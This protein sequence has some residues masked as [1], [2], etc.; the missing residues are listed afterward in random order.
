MQSVNWRYLPVQH[1]IP[2]TCQVFGNLVRQA[3]FEG[4]L[5]DSIRTK[6]QCVALFPKNFSEE[7]TDLEAIDLE[8]VTEHR[9]LNAGG[10]CSAWPLS[11]AQVSISSDTVCEIKW[12]QM[13]A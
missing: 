8:S 13:A 10:S 1:S 11:A 9:K 3:G 6:R 7:G 2:A 4:I 5:Y 12:R